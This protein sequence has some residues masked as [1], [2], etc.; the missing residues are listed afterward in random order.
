[1]FLCRVSHSAVEDHWYT[2]HF[3]YLLGL[4]DL[5]LFSLLSLSSLSLFSLSSSCFFIEA[6][7]SC[8]I[9]TAKYHHLTLRHHK[10]L[11]KY[12]CQ[13]TT[14]NS[15]YCFRTKICWPDRKALLNTKCLL[16]TKRCVAIIL[17]CAQ[18]NSFTVLLRNPTCRCFISSFFSSRNAV[19]M[20]AMFSCALNSS[21]HSSPMNSLAFFP[22]KKP[23]RLICI[24]LESGFCKEMT[25]RQTGYLQKQHPVYSKLKLKLPWGLQYIYTQELI[26]F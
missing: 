12:V 25:G 23:V 15:A 16:N 4:L 19:G 11:I 24:I 5:S 2:V 8:S 13:T 20:P 3:H 6:S 14:K 17:L 21:G 7:F 26:L 18:N 22:F 1:M 9:C 10:D